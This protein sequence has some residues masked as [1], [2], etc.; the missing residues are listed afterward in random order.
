MPVW[1]IIIEWLARGVLLVLFVLSVWSIAIMFDRK[2]YFTNILKDLPSGEWNNEFMKLDHEG[3]KHSNKLWHKAYVFI[4]E[5]KKENKIEKAFETFTLQEKPSMNKGLSVL[6]TL[7]ATAPFIGLFGTVLG[8]INAFGDL[9]LNSQN[10]N[11]IMFLLAEA[12]ILTAV[13]LLV[14]IPAVIA[15]NYFKQKMNFVLERLV[16]MKNTYQNLQD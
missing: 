8:I 1:M 4:S 5:E 13:G 10:T 12:L 14:A 3:V 11:K 15:F 6:G 2:K 9:A 16:A 7:G